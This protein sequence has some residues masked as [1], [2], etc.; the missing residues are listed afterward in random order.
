MLWRLTAIRVQ[1]WRNEVEDLKR[2]LH[3][4]ETAL[5]GKMKNCRSENSSLET[6]SKNE[7]SDLMKGFI[8][9]SL[10]GTQTAKHSAIRKDFRLFF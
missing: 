1:K 2:K 4:K 9:N 10:V 6:V 3:E 5:N 7:S 8:E